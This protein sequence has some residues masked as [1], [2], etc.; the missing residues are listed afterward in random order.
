MMKDEMER[1][2]KIMS[3][4]MGPQR[5]EGMIMGSS[6]RKTYLQESNSCSGIQYCLQ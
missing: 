2:H 1:H 5:G 3:M 6:E 4:M